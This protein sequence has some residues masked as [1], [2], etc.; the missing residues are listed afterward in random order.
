MGDDDTSV[1]TPMHPHIQFAL[2]AA[3]GIVALLLASLLRVP[4]AYSIGA[5]VFFATYIVLVLALMP[6]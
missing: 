4:L 5:N 1:K 3:I 2:S 6:R